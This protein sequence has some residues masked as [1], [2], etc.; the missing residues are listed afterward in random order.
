MRV[1]ITGG[2]G[3]VGS[4][5]AIEMMKDNKDMKI[6]AFDN[7]KRRGSELNIQRLRD[8]NIEFVHGD[9]RNKEDFEN[10][11]DIDIL[12]ECSAEPSALAGFYSGPE[13]VINTNLIGTINCLEYA[14]KHNAGFIFLST[15]RVYPTKKIN[16]LNL[17]E[18]G[19]GFMIQEKQKLNGVSYKGIT[20]DFPLEG[21]RTLYG[22]T[23][24]ASELIIQEYIDMYGIKGIIN[25][26]GTIT[27]AWQMGKVEQGVMALWVAKHHYNKSLSYIGYGGTGKQVRDF[28]HI[29]DLYRLISIQMKDMSKYN[30]KIYNV[31]GGV[32]RSISLLELTKLCQKY[33][34]NKIKIEKVDM[35]RDGDIPVFITD[36]S[37]VTKDTGWKPEISVEEMVA[38]IAEWIDYNSEELKP[39]LG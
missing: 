17:L 20:E 27:G 30:G 4:N 11:K 19:T 39:I 32:E 10:M 26:C 36:N 5:L 25:R 12:I 18:T 16:D 34:G 21:S 1:G 28:I 35:N 31:G 24:L 13:Y 29:K 22:A 14:R 3:F 8:N 2:A 9:I 15:S 38:D 33:T 23:K 37:K 7:L 6:I